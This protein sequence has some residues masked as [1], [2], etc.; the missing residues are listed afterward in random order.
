MITTEINGKYTYTCEGCGM[1]TEDHF[2]CLNHNCDG[3]KTCKT[4]KNR[5]CDFCTAKRKTILPSLKETCKLFE[6]KEG[7]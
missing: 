3:N 5:K 1:K 6:R 4:C 2:F 7:V